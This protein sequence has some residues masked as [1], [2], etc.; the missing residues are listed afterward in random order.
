LPSVTTDK[1][2]RLI[3]QSPKFENHQVVLPREAPWLALYQHE[4]L[5]F[6]NSRNDDQVD[7]TSQ[8][9]KYLT[10][11]LAPPARAPRQPRR[12]SRPGRMG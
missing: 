2:A 7:S 3:A 1:T 6:P 8:A 11:K 5:T 4:L 12:T 9:L 10:S